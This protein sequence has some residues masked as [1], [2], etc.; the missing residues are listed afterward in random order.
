VLHDQQGTFGGIAGG[1]SGRGP[2]T[3]TTDRLDIDGSH[4]VYTATGHVHFTQGDT[5]VDAQTGT[6]NDNTHV[7]TLDGSVHMRQGERT[8]QGDHARYNTVTGDGH[9]EGNVVVTW[10]QGIQRGVATPKPIIIR[11]PKIGGKPTP[12]P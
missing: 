8:L 5:I 7:L 9:V 2:A 10:P 3:L 12:H 11:N 1:G 6:L 4:K